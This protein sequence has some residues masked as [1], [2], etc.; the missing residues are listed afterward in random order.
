MVNPESLK[1]Y[2]GKRRRMFESLLVSFDES[3]KEHLPAIQA[4]FSEGRPEK[5]AQAAHA[6][7]GGAAIIGLERLRSTALS[8]ERQ[9]KKG[10]AACAEVTA[11]RLPDLAAES[12]ARLREFLDESSSSEVEKL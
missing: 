1:H 6:I 9:V 12:L 4:G 10:E 2:S 8:I 11:R 7:A 5:A 3:L